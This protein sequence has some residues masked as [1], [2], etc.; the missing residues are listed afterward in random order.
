ML[1]T[2]SLLRKTIYKQRNDTQRSFKYDFDKCMHQTPVV[3]QNQID[4]V[5]LF[6][7]DYHLQRDRVTHKKK[8]L[9]RI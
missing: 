1:E 6:F 4:R 9:Q 7:I 8:I 3:G 5:L 2:M